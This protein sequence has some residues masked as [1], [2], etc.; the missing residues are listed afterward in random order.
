ME[1]SHS[2]LID[3][4]KNFQHRLILVNPWL[5]EYVFTEDIKRAFEDVLRRPN[6]RIYIGWG[7]WGDLYHDSSITPETKIEMDRF[8]LKQISD[9]RSGD[10][11]YKA[12]EWLSELEQ[13]SQGRLQLKLLYTHQKYLVCDNQFTMIGSHNFL[14]SKPAE[15]KYGRSPDSEVGIKTNDPA[16]IKEI[17]DNYRK[18]RNWDSHG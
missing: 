17:V 14:T 11:K 15:H 2:I 1:A 12:L 18:T 8:K 13:E 5:S 6:S 4:L 16:L 7:F 3:A 10:W 9:R